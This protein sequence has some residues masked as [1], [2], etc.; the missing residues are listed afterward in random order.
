MAVPRE[1][2][3]VLAFEV[4]RRIFFDYVAMTR[5]RCLRDALVESPPQRTD[6]LMRRLF[7]VVLCLAAQRADAQKFTQLARTPPM[8]WNSWNKFQCNVSERLIRET[9]D[10]MNASG[11]KD[12][13]YQFINIDDCWHGARDSLGFIHPDST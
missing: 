9:A 10:A 7:L 1:A 3:G 2:R 8:G 12:A 4:S 11:M 13:G 5:P 6:P